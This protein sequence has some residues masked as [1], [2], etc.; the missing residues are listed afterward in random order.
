MM[1]ATLDTHAL[2]KKLRDSGF[3]EPQAEVLTEALQAAHQA[4]LDVLATKRDLKEL[5]M[6]LRKD[7]AEIKADLTKWVLGVAAGQVALL[8]ALLKLLP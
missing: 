1:T 5:E 3:A 8:V 2:V 7:L 6:E 4:Q